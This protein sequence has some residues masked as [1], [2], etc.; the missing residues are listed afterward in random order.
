MCYNTY[1]FLLLIEYP[2]LKPSD[3]TRKLSGFK[4]YVN[5]QTQCIKVCSRKKSNCDP[6]LDLCSKVLQLT[7]RF[8]P[9]I[10]LS[11]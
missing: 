4:H 3:Q 5:I 6:K 8:K 10:H 2:K 11:L 7:I 9:A 1:N